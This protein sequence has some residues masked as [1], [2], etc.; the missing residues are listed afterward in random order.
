MSSLQKVWGR[1]SSSNTQ[2]VLWML[3]ELALPLELVPASARLGP[4]SEQIVTYDKAFGVVLSPEYAEMNPH[5]R[6]PTLMDS[7]DGTVVWESNT[8]LRYLVAQHTARGGGGGGG[9][10]GA[11]PFGQGDDMSHPAVVAQDSQW[12]DWMLGAAPGPNHLLIDQT[13]RTPRGERDLS[14]VAE[15]SR[16]YVECLSV[17]EAQLER[18]AA[19]SSSL[20]SSKEEEE[21]GASGGDTYLLGPRIRT[22]DFV[23]GVELNRWCLCVH[24]AWADGCGRAIAPGSIPAF[25]RLRR[26]YATLLRRP[27]FVEAVF[28]NELRHQGLLGSSAAGAAGRRKN[29]GGGGGAGAGA[30]A[31]AGPADESSEEPE[32]RP[33]EA[34][35][36]LPG[37]G[38]NALLKKF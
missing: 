14:V 1:T 17:V 19:E 24:K 36:R 15:A 10:G 23:V 31:F 33:R 27:A 13:A 25:P 12:M 8:I 9:G 37:G 26:Y 5:R 20:S 34:Y 7:G 21:E 29:G 6:I 3:K 18:A 32:L 16:A 38:L 35:M 28:D 30:F 4:G 2:K 11:S 22:A